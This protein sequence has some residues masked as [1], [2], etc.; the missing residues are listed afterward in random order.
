MVVES[1]P[2]VRMMY[3]C[4]NEPENGASNPS[5]S[6]RVATHWEVAS[7]SGLGV[8]RPPHG[9]VGQHT[10]FLNQFDGSDGRGRTTHCSRI[11]VH[12]ST[13]IRRPARTEKDNREKQPQRCNASQERVDSHSSGEGPHAVGTRRTAS[14]IQTSD[15]RRTRRFGQAAPL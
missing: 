11:T 10:N 4:S 13:L 9:V 8:A 6:N 1:A 3:R 5:A 14:R 12:L 2:A 7:S 15:A